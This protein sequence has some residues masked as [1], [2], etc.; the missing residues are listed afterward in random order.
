M[1]MHLLLKSTLLLSASLLPCGTSSELSSERPWDGEED[2]E[3]DG[4]EIMTVSEMPEENLM[5]SLAKYSIKYQRC[6]EEYRGGDDA[7]LHRSARGLAEQTKTEATEEGFESFVGEMSPVEVEDAIEDYTIPQTSK[8]ERLSLSFVTF[9]FCVSQAMD[10]P[11]CDACLSEYG[12]IVVDMK[13]YLRS[14]MNYKQMQME[15]YCNTCYECIE[16]ENRPVGFGSEQSQGGGRVPDDVPVR[17]R[18]RQGGDQDFVIAKE[19]IS[20]PFEGEEPSNPSYD[21]CASMNPSQCRDECEDLQSMGGDAHYLEFIDCQLIYKNEDT[22][23]VY[24]VGPSCNEYGQMQISIFLDEEC[25]IRDDTKEKSSYLNDDELLKWRIREIL[26][27]QTF[28][29]DD[30][31]ASCID[32]DDN[33]RNRRQ[34][35]EDKGD[36]NVNMVSNANEDE[37]A[38][39][40][41]GASAASSGGSSVLQTTSSGGNS[42]STSSSGGSGAS[43]FDNTPKVNAVCPTLYYASSIVQPGNYNANRPNGNSDGDEEVLDWA[44]EE[45]W[46]EPSDPENFVGSEE[47]EYTV[48][49][50]NLEGKPVNGLD[51]VGTPVEGSCGGNWNNQGEDEMATE[52]APAPATNQDVDTNSLD[53]MGE[54]KDED[55]EIELGAVEEPILWD[56]APPKW[57]SDEDGDFD[58]QLSDYEEPVD[59]CTCKNEAGIWWAGKFCE[60]KATAMCQ[61]SRSGTEQFCTNGGECINREIPAEYGRI[62]NCPVGFYGRYCEWIVEVGVPDHVGEEM[63]EQEEEDE[64]EDED[65]YEDEAISE[66][67]E[68]DSSAGGGD[69]QDADPDGENEC[70]LKCLN[71][72]RCITWYGSDGKEECEC[73]VNYFG[74]A[75]EQHI[76]SPPQK[77]LSS[78]IHVISPDSLANEVS[79][80]HQVALFGPPN[81]FGKS[82]IV[83]NVYYTDSDLCDSNNLDPIMGYPFSEIDEVGN[84][85]FI[86]MVD[87]GSCTFVQKV[88]NA[89]SIGAWAV[90]FANNACLCMDLDEMNSFCVSDPGVNCEQALP[91]LADD[92]TAEDITIPSFIMLKQDADRIKAD[93]KANKHVMMEMTIQTIPLP[94]MAEPIPVRYELWMTP[95]NAAARAF[96]LGFKETAVSLRGF[97]LFTPRFYIIDGVELG[98]TDATGENDCSNMCTNNGRYCGPNL[99]DDFDVGISG[100]D[101]VRESMHWICIWELF[102]ANIDGVGLQWWDY[103]SHFI[104]KCSTPDLFA[105]KE[106]VSAAMEIADIPPEKIFQCVEDYSYGGMDSDERNKLLEEQI[107][108]IQDRG[109][110]RLPTFHVDQKPVDKAFNSDNALNAICAR[111]VADSAPPVCKAA[112][113][114]RPTTPPPDTESRPPLTSIEEETLEVAA[115]NEDVIGYTTLG[116]GSCQDSL[117]KMY[118]FIQSKFTD[119]PDAA[120][121]ASEECDRFQNLQSYRGFEFSVTKRCTCLFDKDA[122]PSILESE[123]GS[124]AQVSKVNDGNGEVASVSGTPGATCYKTTSYVVLENADGAAAIPASS[125][126]T[127]SFVDNATFISTSPV[128]SFEPSSAPSFEPTSKPSMMPTEEPTEEPTIFST[129]SSPGAHDG[130]RYRALLYI[131]SFLLSVLSL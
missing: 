64:D 4:P 36:M 104:E 14:M 17:E 102:G 32:E 60:H 38:V 115:S 77:P 5:E 111:V 28:V 46:E 117:G 90:I 66:I 103:V 12:E 126:S 40:F 9:R 67:D 54:D 35:Q 108:I 52:P 45:T 19:E 88:R 27:H 43:P 110:T 55:K 62:C 113:G 119:F 118:S 44:E 25:T 23:E 73:P 79:Y 82:S 100:A 24:Y 63:E 15:I 101:V 30:C 92:G 72:G 31:V 26:F 70:T 106:C 122:L 20:E 48:V 71:G 84:E 47:V 2:G 61:P 56:E 120:I 125:T 75:C 94:S 114:L 7:G 89:Q 93:L 42:A 127:G 6:H 50:N 124:Q 34:I 129:E 51:G 99:D 68:W 107:Y 123:P 37:E 11:A 96:L 39:W 59:T 128:P 65:E 21:K 18:Q 76:P 83:A 74:V 1:N 16:N 105:D 3:E 130:L 97:A 22:N 131:T 80:G 81:F 95:A 85:P 121:C 109:I 10:G 58:E 57:A 53:H 78:S 87:R 112:T 116:R 98:C 8:N 69:A 29:S 49:V 13:T 91:V 41:G 86:F 33:D